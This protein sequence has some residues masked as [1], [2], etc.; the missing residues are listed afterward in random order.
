MSG[1]ELSFQAHA[2]SGR[3]RLFPLPNLVMFPHV[4]QPLHIF[5]P[6][7]RALF[8]EALADDRLIA[9]AVLAP[10]WEDDYDG[11]PPLRPTACLGRIVTHQAVEG[12]RYNLLLA[13]LRRVRLVHELPASKPF[14]EARVELV[15]DVYAHDEAGGRAQLQRLL[16]DAF[17]RVLPSMPKVHEQLEELLC[18][19]VSLGMLTDLIAYTLQLPVEIK[20]SLLGEENVDRR[21]R[22]L[23]KELEHGASIVPGAAASGAGGGPSARG[24]RG[25]PKWPPDF[26]AN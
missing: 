5:E 15:E 1:E 18:T 20:E 12:G 8:E 22:I 4:L 17:R 11:R 7:Y 16:L 9:M 26:S 21:C 13:G 19:D 14:R 23:L 10:G 2:F 25:N 6:R 24:T 3:V